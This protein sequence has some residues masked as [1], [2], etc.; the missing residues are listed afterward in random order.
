MQI[1][2]ATDFFTKESNLCSR[3]SI[4]DLSLRHV[5]Q[6]SHQSLADYKCFATFSTVRIPLPQIN[7]YN[8]SLWFN[9]NIAIIAKRKIGYY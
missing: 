2:V 5:H 3:F 1:N 6:F 9:K 8:F 7:K 4:Y